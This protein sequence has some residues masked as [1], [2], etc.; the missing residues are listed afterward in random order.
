LL[1]SVATYLESCDPDEKVT[2]I[3][4]NSTISLDVVAHGA[5]EKLALASAGAKIRENPCD[6]DGRS[7]RTKLGAFADCFE[8]SREWPG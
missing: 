5:V 4:S 8:T 3:A 6:R 7:C 1:Q 2:P